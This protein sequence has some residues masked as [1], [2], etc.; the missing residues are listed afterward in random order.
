MIDLP[1]H[2]VI[3]AGLDHWTGYQGHRIVE[4]RLAA[5]VE[6]L[7]G[8]NYLFYAPPA[9]PDDPNAEATGL[10]VWLF[11][12]WFVA[13]YESHEKEGVRS[14]PL[15]HRLDLDRGMKYRLDRTVNPV[16]V[17][18]VRFVQACTRGHVSDIDWRVFVHGK[19]VACSR[20]LWLDERGTTGDLTDITVRCECGLFKALAASTKQS[21]TPPL[22]FCNGPRP[23]LGAYSKELC[24]GGG[25]RSPMPN[26]L[27]VR[28]ASNAYF[29][30]TLSAI[31]IPEPG[32]ALRA[33]VEEVFADFLQS[34]DSEAQLAFVR[35]MPKVKLAL[36]G[37]SDAEVMAELDRQRMR[38][39][40]SPKG[41]REAE[42]ETLLE[43]PDQVGDDQPEGWFF[44]R[45]VAVPAGHPTITKHISRVVKVHRLRE[46]IVQ[47]GFTRFESSVPDV[48]G[49]LA[50]DVERAALSLN[51][52]W[53]PAVENRGE[54]IFIGFDRDA[55]D[56]WMSRPGVIGRGNQLEAGFNTW[57]KANRLTKPT[58]PGLPYVMLHTLSHLI[59]TAVALDCGYAAS[60]IRERV[61]VGDS[62]YGILLYTATP[63]A[64]GTL[65]GLVES[66][67][68]IDTYLKLAVDMG[69]LCSNDPVCAQHQPDN[70]QEDR[71]L[72]GA[73][74]HG[75]VLLAESSCERRNDFL[76]RA[77][78]VPTVDGDAAAF[79]DIDNV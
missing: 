40:A 1:D 44:A 27:L 66:A 60:S 32:A 3:V 37:F 19:G 9:D 12:E 28:A 46:V 72:A 51:Q 64:E 21:D 74:C 5:K 4:D 2:A 29:A 14:R 18:P 50:L 43:Q 15:V 22:G 57:L 23:W 31:S 78:V 39:P 61:Y 73:A 63:D 24:G 58:F 47:V 10:T 33:A 56:A 52:S 48:N 70:R 55:V 41:I 38:T 67:D 16:K 65:G 77:L 53:L 30:Q 62:G 35:T 69:R 75:C 25:D 13:Q 7:L 26:R 59:I 8:R 42:L 45:S 6:N 68:R 76:D 79:F 20:R 34:V 71:L 17:V 54:G 49:E 11:P 36:E